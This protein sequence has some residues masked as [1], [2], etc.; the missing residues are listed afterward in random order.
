MTVALDGR[1]ARLLTKG[2]LDALSFQTA[3][4]PT[5]A[6]KLNPPQNHA[7]ASYWSICFKI[8]SI[9]IL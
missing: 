6:K 3:S 7:N 9:Q 4:K 2:I 1:E 8:K 5:A